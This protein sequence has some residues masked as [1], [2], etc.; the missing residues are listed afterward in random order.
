MCVGVCVHVCVSMCVHVYVYVFVSM[1][2]C[3]CVCVCVQSHEG[4]LLTWAFLS[5][6]PCCVYSITTFQSVR[7]PLL[8]KTVEDFFVLILRVVIIAPEETGER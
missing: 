3:G 1:C 7:T 5:A 6:W 2:V 4:E 8:E